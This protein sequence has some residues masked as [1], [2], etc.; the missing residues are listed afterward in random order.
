MRFLKGVLLSGVAV[1]A[2][3]CAFT[4]EAT[5]HF[6]AWALSGSSWISNYNGFSESGFPSITGD[7]QSALGE[8]AANASASFVNGS[9]TAYGGYAVNRYGDPVFLG[10]G[11]S[12]LTDQV[13]FSGFSGTAQV[14]FGVAGSYGFSGNAEADESVSDQL[15]VNESTVAQQTVGSGDYYSGYSGSQN[16]PSWQGDLTYTF[17]V[18]PGTYTLEVEGDAEVGPRPV[19]ANNEAEGEATFDPNWYLQVPTGVHYT[20]ASNYQLPS[21]PLSTPEPYPFCVLALALPMALRRR[22]RPSADESRRTGG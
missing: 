21:S 3:V 20:T 6:N 10:I 8:N 9:I 15:L 5:L 22:P 1:P 7:D 12:S 18:T 19:G 13:T 14:T 16:F 4:P 11:G 17:D 2:A